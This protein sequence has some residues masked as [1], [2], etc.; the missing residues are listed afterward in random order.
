MQDAAATTERFA[1]AG[2]QLNDD[3]DLRTAL[4]RC[5]DNAVV[6]AKLRQIHAD[7]D[8]VQ[9]LMTVMAGIG[10]ACLLLLFIIAMSVL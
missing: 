2:R 7:T 9:F 6:L 8:R 10:L 4:R 1:A 5:S 3:F